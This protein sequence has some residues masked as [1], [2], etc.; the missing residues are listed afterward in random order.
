[1]TESDDARRDVTIQARPA[2]AHAWVPRPTVTTTREFYEAH[3][4]VFA[5]LVLIAVVIGLVGWAVGGWIGATVGVLLSVVV[6][7]RGP[8]W[9]TRVREVREH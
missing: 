7:W 8:D 3:R 2:I 5:L 1:M 4:R 6:I 9:R